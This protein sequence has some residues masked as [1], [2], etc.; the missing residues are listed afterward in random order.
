MT[1]IK[2]SSLK[3]GDIFETHSGAKFKVLTEFKTVYQGKKRAK[4]QLCLNIQT[5]KKLLITNFKD[6]I[7]FKK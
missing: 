5:E 4:E 2:I 1:T 6:T 3:A 7:I